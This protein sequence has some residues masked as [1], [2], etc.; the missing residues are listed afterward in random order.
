MWLTKRLILLFFWQPRG[1]VGIGCSPSNVTTVDGGSVTYVCAKPM[2]DGVFHWSL[3]GDDAAGWSADVALSKTGGA[4]YLALGFPSDAGI[5]INSDSWVA[6]AG[7]EVRPYRLDDWSE[8][9]VK[10]ASSLPEKFGQASTSVV[11]DLFVMRI[12]KIT[13]ANPS[14]VDLLY[15]SHPSVAK[16]RFPIE[17]HFKLGFN[18]NLLSG[19]VVDVTS[20]APTDSV[21]IHAAL[22]VF[23]WGWIAPAGIV[24]KC[25]GKRLLKGYKFKGWP[26]AFLAHI[27]LMLSAVVLTVAGVILGLDKFPGRHRHNHKE[28]GL[29]VFALAIYQPLP[30]IFCRPNPETHPLARRVFNVVHK[31]G[32]LTLGV[33]AIVNIYFGTLNFEELN[34]G[35][36]SGGLYLTIV[37]WCLFGGLYLTHEVWRT[38]VSKGDTKK[39]DQPPGGTGYGKTGD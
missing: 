5:M 24:A 2:L 28:I 32:A 37:G 35:S 21:R 15:A 39:Q 11:A 7:E 8:R 4:G 19:K 14:N 38:V 18:I 30:G 6:L 3:E 10:V 16:Q 34:Y 22:M 23:A 33:L 1:A 29:A 17:H 9:G 20:E 31:L 27:F 13:L 26:V 25:A 12:N 36:S